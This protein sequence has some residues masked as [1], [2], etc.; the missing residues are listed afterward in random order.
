MDSDALT[1]QH[2]VQCIPSVCVCACVC[3]WAWGGAREVE[4]VREGAQEVRVE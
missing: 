1:M 4:E 3:Q 2:V